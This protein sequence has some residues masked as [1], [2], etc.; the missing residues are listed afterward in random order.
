M[1]KFKDSISKLEYITYK[2]FTSPQIPP[3][4]PAKKKK[5]TQNA[6]VVQITAEAPSLGH[7]G[8]SHGVHLFS[9]H[10][11]FSKCHIIMLF[12]VK[13]DYVLKLFYDD[14]MGFILR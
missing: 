9:Q 12:N 8:P 5:L 1:P 6:P 10:S 2:L 11:F 4:L 7:V 3:T 14:I 13:H